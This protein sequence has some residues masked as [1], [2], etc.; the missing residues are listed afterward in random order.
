MN[1]IILMD[2]RQSCSSV[3]HD[4]PNLSGAIESGDGLRFMISVNILVKIEIAQF[5]IDEEKVRAV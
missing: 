4:S 2:K 5:H 3:S 1:D